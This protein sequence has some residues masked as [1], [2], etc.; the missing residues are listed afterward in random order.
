[1]DTRDLIAAVIEPGKGV[2]IRTLN[3]NWT[4][5][6]SIGRDGII[7]PGAELLTWEDANALIEIAVEEALAD[8]K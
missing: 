6:K 7:I 1:M 3:D 8:A 4:S 2:A 5:V